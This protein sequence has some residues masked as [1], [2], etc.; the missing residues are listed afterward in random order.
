EIQGLD[1][2]TQ[3]ERFTADITEEEIDKDILGI[4]RRMGQLQDVED[5]SL[6]EGDL[7]SIHIHELENGQ[8]REGGIHN[9]FVLRLDEEID[10]PF[11][12]ELKKKKIGETF[13]FDPFKINKEANDGYVRRYYL[14]LEEDPGREIGREFEGRLDRVRRA[15]LPPL[16]QALFDQYFGEGEVSS[17]EEARQRIR[18]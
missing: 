18:E 12:E 6:E 4:R 8:P 13:T 14:G 17:E 9:H 7:L 3:L 11:M 5:G 1:E 15:E 2:S 10:E 16:D